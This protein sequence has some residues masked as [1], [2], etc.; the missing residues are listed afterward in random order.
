[1]NPSRF[2]FTH[3]PFA[4]IPRIEH[5]VDVGNSEQIWKQCVLSL[6]R[7]DGPTLLLGGA[8]MGKTMTCLQIAQS[9]SDTCE[10]IFLS[11][12]QIASRADL[13]KS[14]LYE[15]RMPYRGLFDGELRLSLVDRLQNRRGAGVNR[16]V[17]IVDEAQALS[18]RILEEIRLLT[19]LAVGG[20]PCLH[21]ILCGSAKLEEMLNHSQLESLQQRIASRH[22]LRPLNHDECREYLRH[23][24]ELAGVAF[25]RVFD[26]SATDAIQLLSAGIPRLIDQLADRAIAL[27]ETKPHAAPINASQ[28]EAA[29]HSLHQL[30]PPWMDSES[31]VQISQSQESVVA[32]E[33]TATS[34]AI[35]FDSM[36]AVHSPIDT[37]DEPTS[38]FDTETD[39]P[40]ADE[41]VAADE[42]S[43]DPWTAGREAQTAVN[44]PNTASYR[45]GVPPSAGMGLSSVIA[46]DT[47]ADTAA[48][49]ESKTNANFF[50]AELDAV[51]QSD[52]DQ[53]D[54][55][56]LASNNDFDETLEHQPAANVPTDQDQPVPMENDEV[57]VH[58]QPSSSWQLD[59]KA[60]F[61]ATTAQSHLNDE[62]FEQ[63]ASEV[64]HA[65]IEAEHVTSQE[66]PPVAA[67]YGQQHIDHVR[68][69]NNTYRKDPPVQE[70]HSIEDNLLDMI[71][72][73]NMQ[74]IASDPQDNFEAADF[75]PIDNQLA[76]T[77]Q[78]S[79]SSSPTAFNSFVDLTQHAGSMFHQPEEASATEYFEYDVTN[80]QSQD[81][82]RQAVQL[83][84]RMRDLE[85]LSFA[86]RSQYAGLSLSDFEAQA[87]FVPT[88]DRDIIVI[89]EEVDSS[90]SHSEQVNK[91]V[92]TALM[93]SYAKLFSELRT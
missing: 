19:N 71:S 2:A 69:L 3:R 18:P 54:Y 45:T 5:F 64:E 30:S 7:N 77:D 8:G 79:L 53:D 39:E 12:S 15:L 9:L 44:H 65:N 27:S 13:L 46:R 25:E 52:N 89:D 22:I 57:V 38:Y 85:N 11:S 42:L 74:S 28:I 80:E 84:D 76:A 81:D 91:P 61:Q 23:K 86:D 37:D 17:L 32:A 48:T 56:Q 1:M 88:D 50:A 34:A 68:K 67:G 72:S 31:N 90:W 66:L 83:E 70:T 36:V 10:V 21:L 6:E 59:V 58:M 49:S 62:Q 93:Q 51:S 33:P 4:A 14:L 60:Y 47:T 55:T 41:A 43:I 20:E 16:I 29:W 75:S 82:D 24:I 87:S 78:P 40:T 73:M 35:A 63:A 26:Y 92:A